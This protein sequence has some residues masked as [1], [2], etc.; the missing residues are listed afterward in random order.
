[1]NE[2][3][4]CL[5]INKKSIMKFYIKEYLTKGY[6]TIPNFI[7]P[8]LADEIKKT[9][10]EISVRKDVDIYYDRS[11]TLRRMEYF[12]FKNNLLKNLNEKIKKL[13]LSVTS[14]KQAL[15][16]DKVNFKPPLGEGFYAHYDGIFQFN[17]P[18]GKIKN[19]WYE[20][21][22]NFN[23]VLIALDDFTP[24]NGPLEVANVC[25]G[26]FKKLLKDTKLDG[27]PEIKEE[28]AR[29]MVFTPILISKGSI[30]VFKH[31]C[32]HRSSSNR[33]SSERGSMYL[34]YTNA[35]DGD[36]YEQYFSDKHQ[37]INTHKSLIGEK[38]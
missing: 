12:T 26:D 18:D 10:E 5:F 28:L 29:K 23:N 35:D 31:N 32:P 6:F 15:F 27:T 2:S 11:G 1:M 33:S 36:F 34:T 25:H 30:I 22:E 21:A 19:G 14:K 8:D 37:S 16:K 24:L 13:L 3:V 4:N 9:V 20:Y 17:T 7:L 38:T